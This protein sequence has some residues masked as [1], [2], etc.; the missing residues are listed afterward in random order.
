M[1]G[2]IFR[3]AIGC[4][5][6]SL[7]SQTELQAED[8]APV[9]TQAAGEEPL[10]PTE[11][12]KRLI[13][14]EGFRITLAAA[15]PDV[16]QPI[17]ITFDDRGR[18]WVAESYSYDGSTFTDEPRDRILIFE[19]T[20]GD[21]V[22]DRRKV[23]CDGLTHLTGLEIGFGGVWITAPPSLSFIPDQ[24]RDDV[25]DG[26]AVVHLDG[27]SLKA[28]HNSV[29]GLTWGPDGWLYGR[30]GIKQPSHVGRPGDSAESRVELSCCI[31]RYHPTRH[32]FEV[33]ADGT[34]NPWGLD[35]DDHGQGFLTTSVVEHLWHLVPGAH[36]ERW[37]DRGVH[38]NPY[39]YEAMS[40]TSDHLHWASGTWD[41][42]GR[43]ED[44]NHSH[45]GGHSHCDAMIYLGDRW[46]D[47]YRGTLL[48]SNIHGRRLNRDR[49]VRKSGVYRGEHADDFLVADDPWFRAV[50]M[51]Y[52]PDGDVYVTDW[53]DN[54]EC[55]DR[56]GVHRTSGRIY[57]ITW[58]KPL[59]VNVDLQAASNEQLVNYQLHRNDWYVRHARRILQERSAAG[60]N[61]TAAH[62]ELRRL[63]DEN[64]DVTRKLR[65]L[66]VLY[67]TGGTDDEWLLDLLS[68][69]SEHVRSWAV[70]LLVDVQQPTKTAL[71]QFAKTAA[72]EDS[73]LVQISLA[74]AMQRL[75][76]GSRWPVVSGLASRLNSSSDPNL[77]RMIWFAMEPEVAANPQ[78]AIELTRLTLPRI[79]RWTARRLTEHSAESVEVLFGE[80]GRS[81]DAEALAD[82]LGGFND[83]LPSLETGELGAFPRLIAG[84]LVDH[85]DPRVRVEAVTAAA[86]IGD[87]ATLPRIRRVLH[88]RQEDPAT[89]L[90]ALTGLVRRKH[91]E[92]AQDLLKLI[93]ARQLTIPALQA[94]AVIGDPTIAARIL[95]RFSTFSAA[96]R[97]A[98]VDSLVARRIS[99]RLLVNAIELKHIASSEVSAGQAR[100]IAALGDA[101]LLKRLDKVWGT[102]RK[103]PA[104][105]VRQIRAWE[106][107]LDP[108]RIGESDLANGRE[109][110]KKTCSSCHKLFGDGR[111]IGPELT[112]AN[113]RNLNY[114]L[115]NVVDPSAAV[116]ADFRLATVVTTNGRVITGAISQRS[117]AGLTIQTSTESVRVS[118]GDV[119]VV[120]VSKQSMMP[121]GLLDKLSEAQTRDLF[122]W[123]MSDGK[124]SETAQY[125][126]PNAL[127]VVILLGDSI[128]MNYQQ[129]VVA[130]LKG[131]A[132]VWA[133]K[134]NCKH[135][136]FVLENLEKW[137]K[138][139]NA[140]VVHI[141]VGLHDMFLSS[142]TDQPRHSLEV[143]E[144][145]IRAIFAKL[146]ELTDAKIIFALTTPVIESRQAASEGYKRI[147]RRAADVVKYNAKVTQIADAAG[148]EVNDLHALSTRVGTHDILR[149]S[150]GIH[151]SKIGEEVIGKHVAT[152]VEKALLGSTSTGGKLEEGLT[153]IFN[154]ADL[155][156]WDGKPGAWKVHDGEIWCTGRAEEKNWLIWRAQQPSDFALRLEFRWDKGNSG[157]QV[158]SDDLGNW[159]VHG[160]QVEVAKQSVMGLWHHSLLDNSH[161]RKQARHLM[162]TAGQQV[163]LSSDGSKIVDQVEHADSFKQRF[164]E[165]AWNT[166]EIVAE[167]DTL[168]QR[169]NGVV[170]SQVTDRDE[171]MRRRKGFIA[172]QDHGK[173]CKVAFRNIRLRVIKQTSP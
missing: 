106:K 161:P 84:K 137:V 11:A 99:A 12:I 40:A 90:S 80:L 147:V 91:P 31:W 102:L 23:F 47:E 57:K 167:G 78:Q 127:P 29:N 41:K 15:E 9:D 10:A 151:L 76:V 30:H 51:E 69:Q 96:D 74:S 68:H 107:Q 3:T 18:L 45:G 58:G 139:R 49:L 138:G 133:P 56:D 21:G 72:S 39:V 38:P 71:Q 28:E 52:G 83:G 126:D 141:N 114:L 142:S 42:A 48:T 111:T 124:V 43:M 165:H 25:P 50:S 169:I 86:T 100:Q 64:T 53:S 122:A 67:V 159:M 89:R 77:Q 140:S 117:D 94:A 79:R 132:T 20:N 24:D 171:E 162:A 36:F 75:P 108:S 55:H 37:K 160:Y 70:R 13:V 103:S 2:S 149:E 135:T 131:K 125:N 17:A 154:G 61:M 93:E 168:I 123:M 118:T 155:A 73:W 143:Y 136:A 65:A 163:V 110:F 4:L 173:G 104:A 59:R 134:E 152:S 81:T 35:F 92:L 26:D 54:G 7:V 150:D 5:I 105:R 97:S 109:V 113:R 16:R 157:V 87:E 85:A 116:P 34:I 66:W 98:V 19:D 129:T 170:F 144:T 63:F 62:A 60:Q 130:E 119:E 27:W 158:R 120:K 14:P 46:P 172:L 112:G 22:L 156:G 8:F 128:R 95:Y 164:S 146:K 32:M 115:T 148:I 33:V 166:L 153:A 145:N 1:A 6:L 82:L 121:D 44:G 88:D 101:D